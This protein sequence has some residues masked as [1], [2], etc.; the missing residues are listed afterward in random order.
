MAKEYMLKDAFV[1][2]VQYTGDNV[3]EVYE[4]GANIAKEHNG[5]VICE[6]SL[7]D[8]IIKSVNVGDYLVKLANGY[9]F[10]LSEAEFKE[11]YFEID[12]RTNVC[13]T[14]FY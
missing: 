14:S 6:D 8:K 4:F 13:M 1:T 7:T 9:A 10:K 12:E 5:L 11:R 3:E 2:A